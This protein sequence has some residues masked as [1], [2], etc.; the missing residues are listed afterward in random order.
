[1][2]IPTFPSVRLTRPKV[3]DMDTLERDGEREWI[4]QSES[5]SQA[6]R[7]LSDR[8][9]ERICLIQGEKELTYS[10][11]VGQGAQTCKRHIRIRCAEG[12]QV[13][14]LFSSVPRVGVGRAS[15]E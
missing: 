2:E 6:F 1:M 15:A 9:V 7:H 3:I 14:L 5:L 8:Y 13:A 12:R 10:Q 11:V 4:S